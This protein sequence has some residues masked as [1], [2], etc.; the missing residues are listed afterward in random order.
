MTALAVQRR[1]TL[2]SVAIIATSIALSVALSIALDLT[3]VLGWAGADAPPLVLVFNAAAILM[4]VVG[5]LIEWRRPGHGIGRLLLLS[6]PLLALLALAWTAGD[7]LAER[8][9][10][11]VGAVVGWAGIVLSY[12]GMALIAGWLPLLFPTGSLPSPRWRLP[13]A[14]I[15]VFTTASLMALALRP[16]PIFMGGPGNPFGVA[17]W[18]TVLQPLADGLLLEL[19]ALIAFG[20]AGL[21]TRYRHGGHVERQQI[22]WLLAAMCIIFAAFAGT[23]VESTLRTDDGIFVSAV[24]A[25]LGILALPL[26]IG[27]AILRYRLYEIDR[28]ISRT[29]GYALVTGVLLAVF[30]CAVL[31]LQT[32]LEPLTGENTVA[33]AASTLLVAALF[34]PLRR[35]IQS[36][37]DR[38]F[39]RAR[40]D[41]ERTIAAFAARLRDQVDLDSLE[42][43][44]GRVVHQTVA[45]ATLGL[46]VQQPGAVE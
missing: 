19:C 6:G 32:V 43:E 33:V 14:V 10:P 16:G 36:A 40:Y 42:G 39:D 9:D 27:V 28:L 29:I 25:Y 7:A 37:V 3:I 44:L 2:M 13:A 15:I 21:A 35:R 22:R 45:P 30:A 24:L 38:R 23:F 11:A 20:I 46:W 18:P 17:W 8:M 31:G 12:P 1:P 4:A 34:Q 5:A 41:G 26:A